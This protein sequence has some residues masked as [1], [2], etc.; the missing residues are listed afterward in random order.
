MA[1]PRSTNPL[2]WETVNWNSSVRVAWSLCC[3]SLIS[4]NLFFTASSCSLKIRTSSSTIAVTLLWAASIS[5]VLFFMN[6]FWLSIFVCTTPISA[7]ALS[8][9]FVI[10]TFLSSAACWISNIVWRLWLTNPHFIQTQVLQSL[11]KYSSD[12]FSWYFCVHITGRWINSSTSCACNFSIK[13]FRWPLVAF[14]RWCASRQVAQRKLWQTKQYE[15][16]ALLSSQ[17]LHVWICTLSSFRAKISTS[18]LRW[19]DVGKSENVSLFG[20]LKSAKHTGHLIIVFPCLLAYPA[21][22]SRH[23]KQNECKHGSVFGSL[24]VSKH[25]GHSASFL[26]LLNNWW[27]SM[28]R[29]YRWMETKELQ[30]TLTLR[31]AKRGSGESPRCVTWR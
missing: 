18:R 25:S 30:V 16:T 23:S 1:L 6:S 24:T 11:Q 2:S 26:R 13:T 29:N 9:A 8:T 31:F 14:R 15:V 28:S 20:M 17:L 5:S 27:T 22:L 12:S 4:V 10:W 7:F 21:C 19:N 3:A